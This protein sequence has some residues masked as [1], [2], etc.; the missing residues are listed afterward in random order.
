V[1]FCPYRF[2]LMS[3]ARQNVFTIVC[4][5]NVDF[6]S[7]DVWLSERPSDV[8]FISARDDNADKI[9]ETHGLICQEIHQNR[10]DSQGPHI[11]L[12]HLG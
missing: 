9:R 3:Y 6:V 1:P 10:H 4:G 5:D 12:M 8:T 2:H 11:H 7:D